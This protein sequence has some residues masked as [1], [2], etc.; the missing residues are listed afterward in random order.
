MPA[1]RSRG[2]STTGP[3]QPK[4]RSDA[5]T[6]LLILSLVAQ[7]AGA[8]FL[9]LDFSRYPASAPTK[10]AAVSVAPA[11]GPAPPGANPVPPNPVP[12][13]QPVPPPVVPPAAPK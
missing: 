9:Y 13:G 2:R 7:I 5:Y 6:G 3:G 1:V 12:P 4:P 10:V 11:V 8:V